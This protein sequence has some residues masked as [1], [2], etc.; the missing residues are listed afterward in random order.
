[1]ATLIP[2]RTPTQCRE[3]WMFRIGPGLNKAPFQDWED[4]LI[5]KEREKLGNHWTSI[6]GKLPGRTSCAVKS[7]W[8]SVLKNRQAQL[9]EANALD[10]TSLLSRP[11]R[12]EFIG[13]RSLLAD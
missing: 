3:R 7:R 4:E 1:V 9:R 5:I 6:A 13:A 10:I 8:Y 2:G 11:V 12:T